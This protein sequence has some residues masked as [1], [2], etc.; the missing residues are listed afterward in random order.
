MTNAELQER[1]AR[2]LLNTYGTRKI[3]LSRGEGIRVW[4][5]E[6][7]EYLDFFSGIAVCNLGH[8]HPAITETICTQASKLLHVSNLFLIEPQIYL[9]EL[10][11]K[12]SFAPYWFFCNSGAEANEAAVKLARRYAHKQGKPRPVVLTAEGSFHGR[13]LAMITATGQE[14]YRVGFEPLLPGIRYFQYNDIK[15]VEAALSDEVGAV[16]IEPIQGEGG[17][18]PAEPEFLQAL[19]DLCTKHGIIL[20]FDEV[21]TGLG[22]TGHLFAYEHYGIVPDVITL[23]KALANGVPMGAMG[24]RETFANGFEPGT[25]AATFGGNPLSSAVALTAVEAFAKPELLEHV[26]NVGQYFLRRLEGLR[27]KHKRICDIRGV[28]LML[29]VEF[30]QPVAPLVEAMRDDGI[31]CGSAGPNVLRFLPPLIVTADQIDTA[32]AT[33]SRVLGSLGW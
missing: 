14:K 1:A 17:V 23:A 7:K 12:V 10:L 27:A 15:S 31:L 13:T 19:R 28:G 22:R 4:D 26:R 25:H 5:V 3:A 18:R 29:G 20:I 9:A 30:N 32:I 33:L 6:G 11:A 2:V 8:A 16:L 24:C 21:Q